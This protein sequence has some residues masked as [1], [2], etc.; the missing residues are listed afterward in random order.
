MDQ[1]NLDYIERAQS[2][3]DQWK[4]TFF[5]LFDYRWVMTGSSS[6]VYVTLV[7]REFSSFSS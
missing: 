6:L 1:T 5:D 2:I 3:I 7:S 4:F